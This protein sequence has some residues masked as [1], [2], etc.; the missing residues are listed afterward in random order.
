M[1]KYHQRIYREAE[2]ADD[3]QRK[4]REKLDG[5]EQSG[6]KPPE[7]S[8]WRGKGYSSFYLMGEQ[9]KNDDR[10]TACYPW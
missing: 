4:R 1:A 5:G 9:V 10:D 6:V 8:V 7:N 3:N 2:R